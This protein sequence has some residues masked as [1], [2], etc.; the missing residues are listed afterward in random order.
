MI[1]F[2]SRSYIIFYED[3]I[4]PIVCIVA[5]PTVSGELIMIKLVVIYGSDKTILS[6]VHV[7]L[8]AYAH[9]NLI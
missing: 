3:S 6:T 9:L 2:L 1:D 8:I 7:I 4:S 5:T